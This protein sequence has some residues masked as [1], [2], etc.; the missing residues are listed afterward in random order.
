MR[1]HFGIALQ[2]IALAWLPL[3]IVYQLELGFQLL[4]MP[5]CTVI[6]LVVFWIGTRLRES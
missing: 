2:I 4:V 5:I 1:H 3:V 6:G